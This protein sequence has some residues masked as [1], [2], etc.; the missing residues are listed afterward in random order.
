MSDPTSAAHEKWGGALGAGYQIVPNVLL[1]AQT[2]LGLDCVDCVILLNLRLHWWSKER[3][4]FPPPALI[5]NR[6]GVSRRTVERRLAKLEKR[7]WIKRLPAE[8]GNDGTPK[9]RRFVMSGTAERLSDAAR[10]GVSQRDYRASRKTDRR[11]LVAP[12]PQK[13]LARPNYEREL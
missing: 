13:L 10:L 6:I 2:K 11:A 3:L 8:G 12:S 1:Q 7:G 4:P 9:I 5:A